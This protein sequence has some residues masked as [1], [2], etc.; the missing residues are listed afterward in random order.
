[1]NKNN[2]KQKPK[3]KRKINKTEKPE[4]DLPVKARSVKN[5]LKEVEKK[6]LMKRYS[7]L[8]VETN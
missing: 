4:L 6:C 8:N 2:K 7:A 1:M 5:L 3:S